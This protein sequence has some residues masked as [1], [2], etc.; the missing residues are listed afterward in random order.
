MNETWK[1]IAGYETVYEVSDFGRVRRLPKGNILK[2][3]TAGRGYA[4]VGLS[5]DGE[6][7]NKY[8]HHL[9]AEAHLGPRPNGL[10]ICHRNGDITDPRLANL[11]YGTHHSN[12][13]DSLQHGTHK[14]VHLTHCVNGHELTPD[15]VH[16]RTYKS[17][18]GGPKYKN[19]CK[20]CRRAQRR[21]SYHASKV[22]K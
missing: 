7:T 10:D 14:S 21:R 4:T 13:R 2:H 20:T 3:T 18:D 12:M 17:T 19:Q 8:V 22:P 1:P 5:Q 9:V 15:N 11:R 16:R 6:A